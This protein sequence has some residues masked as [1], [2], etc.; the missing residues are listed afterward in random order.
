MSLVLGL[1]FETTGLDPKKD[2]IIE[3]GAVLWDTDKCQI[4]SLYSDLIY[5]PKYESLRVPEVEKMV[6]EVTGL[7]W[8][9]LRTYGV[10]PN[11]FLIGLESICG[12][13]LYAHEVGYFVAH[14]G[15]TFDRPFLQALIGRSEMDC[16]A[17]LNTPWI[18]TSTDLPHIKRPDSR[19]LKH[20]AMEMG[21]I[22]PFPHRALFDVATMMKV[23]GQFKF[24]EILAYKQIPW[25][26]V[27][28]QVPFDDRQLAKDQKYQWERAG[29]DIFHRKWVKRIKENELSQER[30]RCPFSIVVL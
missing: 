10:Y 22:N 21:F 23:F 11:Q 9:H 15:E 7:S 20:L 17:I 24:E 13:I 5:C 27:Q 6:R 19:K 8:D 26:V 16:P 29:N 1:D 30:A 12:S 4:L 3:W 2:R 14:N 25:I 28:A 18:D